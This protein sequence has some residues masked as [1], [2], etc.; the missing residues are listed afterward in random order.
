MKIRTFWLTA[1]FLSLF[2]WASLTKAQ[3]YSARKLTQKIAPQP[4]PTPAT[5]PHPAMAQ[6]NVRVVSTPV[7]AAKTSAISGASSEKPVAE[8]E[9]GETVESGAEG[10]NPVPLIIDSKPVRPNPRESLQDV[11]LSL[12][13]AAPTAIKNV[14]M[15]LIYLDV[16]G[17]KLGEWTTRRQ[18]EPPLAGQSTMQLEQPAFY[19]PQTARRMKVEVT[20]VGFT[21]GKVWTRGAR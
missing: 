3:V 18:I 17:T 6:P 9:A 11:S 10:A 15:R 12:T 7:A 19:M 5:A 14:T 13:N 20:E 2:C 4:T 21:D 8:A 16:Q 1:T